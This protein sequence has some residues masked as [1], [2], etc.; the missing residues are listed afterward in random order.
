MT[1]T[2]NLAVLPVVAGLVAGTGA[3]ATFM[4]G[5]GNVAPPQAA[6]A[7]DAQTWPYIDGK[8]ISRKAEDERR[9][10]IVAAPRPG[11]APEDPA[12]A[13]PPIPHVAAPQ[14]EP[15]A[16]PKNLTTRDTVLRSPEIVAP[17]RKI[18]RREKRAE[19]RRERRERRW[20]QS[21][22]V[23]EEANGRQRAVIVVRPLR[24]ESFR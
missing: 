15:A 20:A 9:V 13:A 2:L 3:L 12:P 8:C 1:L 14:P 24:L 5:P 11:E 21:Y 18:A 16:A 7:C 10:R 19:Q 22:S 17:P 23:P 6:R 4:T